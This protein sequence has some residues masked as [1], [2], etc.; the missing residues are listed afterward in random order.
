MAIVEIFSEVQ[1]NEQTI[2][3]CSASQ[4]IVFAEAH[5]KTVKSASTLAEGKIYQTNNCKSRL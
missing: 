2:A 5:M 1:F 3:G 4:S